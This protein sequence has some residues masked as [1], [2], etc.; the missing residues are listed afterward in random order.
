MHVRQVHVGI[1]YTD[2]GLGVYRYLDIELQMQDRSTCTQLQENK[3]LEEVGMQDF[4]TDD[5]GFF[6]TL[7]PL[8]LIFIQRLSI[9]ITKIYQIFFSSV[10]KNWKYYIPDSKGEELSTQI[11][12]KYLTY[13]YFQINFVSSN[14]CH[15]FL[16]FLL[17]NYS[18]IKLSDNFDVD[19]IP[20]F[21]YF[22]RL[23]S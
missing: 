2:R 4:Q 3:P 10:I 16:R 6:H 9:L 8:T 20:T 12:W 22:L 23:N 13:F 18:C 1:Q 21:L 17:N 7:H 5:L 14:L 19:S 11:Q 15:C